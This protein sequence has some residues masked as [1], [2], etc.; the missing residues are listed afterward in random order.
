MDLIAAEIEEEVI[1][2]IGNTSYFPQ[3]GRYFRYTTYIDSIKFLQEARLIV[4]HCSTGAVINA[5]KFGKPLVVVPRRK[6]YGEH[7][8]EHQIELAQVIEK[9]GSV[10]VVY[11]I[12]RLKEEVLRILSEEKE[13]NLVSPKKPEGIIKAIQTFLT[14]IP[15][16]EEMI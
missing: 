6:A 8:D 11:D 10:R 14:T 9:E 13:E 3:N 12:K 4:S 15:K 1:F 7:F 16:R 2:Q 5:K